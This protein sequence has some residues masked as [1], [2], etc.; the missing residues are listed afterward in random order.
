MFGARRSGDGR[1]RGRS[2]RCPRVPARLVAPATSPPAV[3]AVAG[4]TAGI[5][6][7]G[8]SLGMKPSKGST[9]PRSSEHLKSMNRREFAFGLLDALQIRRT[10]FKHISVI[11]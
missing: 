1:A 6:C 7:P 9:S 10:S 5:S 2:N 11:K 3:A 4:G 8:R